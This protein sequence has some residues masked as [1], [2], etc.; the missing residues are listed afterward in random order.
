MKKLEIVLGSLAIIGVL[1]NF[2]EIAGGFIISIMSISFLSM[3]YYILSFALLNDIKFLKI[4]DKE[5]YKGVGVIDIIMAILTGIGL[6]GLILGILF[7]LQSYPGASLM[8]NI[9]MI[10]VGIIIVVI[11][12]LNFINRLKIAKNILIRAIL[13]VIAGL[14]ILFLH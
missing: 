3:F 14:L 9:H 2:F 7:K 1:M 11:S 4:F 6:S 13:P 12:V 5:S 8:L 10:Y